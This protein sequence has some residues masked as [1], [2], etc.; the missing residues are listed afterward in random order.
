VVLVSTTVVV[1]DVFEI[2]GDGSS[3][4]V[5][6]VADAGVAVVAGVGVAHVTGT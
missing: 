5:V 2:V 4:S 6:V 3:G 1:V